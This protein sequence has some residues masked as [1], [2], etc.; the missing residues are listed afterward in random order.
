[1]CLPPICHILPYLMY[2]VYKHLKYC[3]K[4]EQIK[5]LYS[6]L[7]FWIRALS[8]LTVFYVVACAS[9]HHGCKK[10]SKKSSEAK[11]VPL[12]LSERENGY[13]QGTNLNHTVSWKT[14]SLWNCSAKNYIHLSLMPGYYSDKQD[15]FA[16]IPAM[17]GSRTGWGGEW[18]QIL[19]LVCCR[20]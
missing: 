4:A 13:L 8:K 17:W 10:M 16:I 20:V 2:C 6:S 18:E 5:W 11:I 15:N 9:R 14:W 12:I 7:Q 3:F 19:G 1:M